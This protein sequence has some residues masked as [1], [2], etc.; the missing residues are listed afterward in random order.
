MAMRI[1]K[2]WKTLDALTDAA[3]D[4]REWAS[5]LG[6]EFGC[7][8]VNESGCPL[9]LVRSTGTPATSIACPSPGGEGCP[10]RVVHHDDGTFRAV[11]GDSP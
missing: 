7:V 6:D 9:P 4:R 5:L 3:T 2:F 1:S 11:C 8:V 10:R